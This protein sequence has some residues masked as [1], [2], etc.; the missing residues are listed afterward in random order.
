MKLLASPPVECADWPI[1]DSIRVVGRTRY[2]TP[3]TS[4]WADWRDD[5]AIR[6]HGLRIGAA[7]PEDIRREIVATAMLAAWDSLDEGEPVKTAFD[8]IEQFCLLR[9]WLPTLDIDY[10]EKG[11]A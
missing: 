3:P 8:P 1:E 6:R 9:D 10:P 7:T 2:L 5:D 11:D 4:H